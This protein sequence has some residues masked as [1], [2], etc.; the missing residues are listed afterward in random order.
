[1]S[2][3]P[4]LGFLRTAAVLPSVFLHILRPYILNI[5]LT[6][7]YDHDI[8]EEE[9]CSPLWKLISHSAPH[10]RS[11]HLELSVGDSGVDMMIQ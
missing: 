1:M 8:V 5:P 6:L 7:E 10:L 11:L 2:I 3:V 9:Q 4:Q